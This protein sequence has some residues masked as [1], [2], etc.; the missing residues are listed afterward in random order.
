VLR[1][2]PLAADEY[3]TET[4]E[5]VRRLGTNA[6]EPTLESELLADLGFDSLRVIE[7]IAELEERYDIAVPLNDL[8]HIRTVA[9]IAA[10]VRELVAERRA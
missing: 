9:E 8:A 3:E 2:V 7:L 1:I 10:K 4:L 6:T 5:V